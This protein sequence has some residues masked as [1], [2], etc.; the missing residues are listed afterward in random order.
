MR[1][2]KYDTFWAYRCSFPIEGAVQNVLKWYPLHTKK[3]RKSQKRYADIFTS[4]LINIRLGA[5]WNNNNR[6]DN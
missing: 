2:V 1:Y 3:L 5:N 6:T 4:V